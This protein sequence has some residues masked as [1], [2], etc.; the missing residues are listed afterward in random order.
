MVVKVK[1]CVSFDRVIV[2]EGDLVNVKAKNG[3]VII[4]KVAEVSQF[5]D[6]LKLIGTQEDN[7][8]YVPFEEIESIEIVCREGTLK[9]E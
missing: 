3:V 2:V 7:I 1:Q 9:D 5:L 4:S 6:D 8:I